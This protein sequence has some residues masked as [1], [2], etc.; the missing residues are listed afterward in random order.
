MHQSYL[1]IYNL[2]VNGHLCSDESQLLFFFGDPIKWGPRNPTWLVYITIA[3]PKDGQII[4][5]WIFL[6][7]LRITNS[8]VE[9]S[10]SSHIHIESIASDI[11]SD[12]VMRQQKITGGVLIWRRLHVLFSGLGIF[13]Q[14]VPELILCSWLQAI[15]WI[16]HW[17]A[18]NRE[19]LHREQRNWVKPCS[20]G[21][22]AIFGACVWAV[23]SHILLKR[24]NS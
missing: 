18:S 22:W 1:D 7:S 15:G 2:C 14:M 24:Q 11:A 17:N 6:F 21:E 5:I 20:V 12:G 3:P 8:T 19:L 4:T 16:S 23:G 9:F 10:W 13:H